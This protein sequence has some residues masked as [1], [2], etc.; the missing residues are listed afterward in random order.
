MRLTDRAFEHIVANHPELEPYLDEILA[1]VERPDSCESD[2]F[3]GRERF[4]RRSV[5]PSGWLRVV[6]EY[7]RREAGEIDGEV[8]TAHGDRRGPRV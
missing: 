2:P 7:S 6:V 5:G 4:Y 3:M 1:T 8:I